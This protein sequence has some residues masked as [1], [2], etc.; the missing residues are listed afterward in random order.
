MFQYLM[1]ALQDA[2]SFI[3]EQHEPQSLDISVY[4]QCF[5]VVHKFIFLLCRIKCLHPTWEH[6]QLHCPLLPVY[7]EVVDSP[8]LSVA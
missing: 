7:V 4:T 8:V 3:T 2:V 6:E 5:L 1:S